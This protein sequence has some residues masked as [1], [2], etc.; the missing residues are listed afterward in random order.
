[1]RYYVVDD[2]ISTIMT[3]IDVIDSWELGTVCGYETDPVVAVDKILE[4][5]PD[6]VL[7][8]ML[9]SK[10]DGITLVETVKKSNNNI[11]FV[12]ISKVLDKEI[13][14][15]AYSAGI[16]FFINKPI[17]KTEVSQVIANVSEKVE[18]KKAMGT[19]RTVLNKDSVAT[20]S[21]SRYRNDFYDSVDNLFA[22]LGM[23]GERGTSDIKSI[24]KFMIENDCKY[25]KEA[26]E[27]VA[28]LN[29]DTPR[30]MEQRIRRAIRKGLNN[31]A[32]AAIDDFYSEI[33]T[34][35]GN[36]VF[37]FSTIK[38]EMSFVKNESKAGGRINIAK[39]MEGLVIYRESTK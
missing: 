16:E 17:N 27:E 1:M 11:I 34:V 38:E 21:E 30:N 28:K 7:V 31:V 6:I 25:S 2:N 13:I 3:L 5:N 22:A 12:M 36:Y 15:S 33:S 19:I 37:E 4:L 29:K 35:Y 20:A 23:L 39:F 18:L 8:D 26:L 32:V 24:F 14:Q 9:M 10:M